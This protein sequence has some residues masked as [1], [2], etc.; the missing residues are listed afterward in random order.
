MSGEGG[1][2]K[3]L[4]VERGKGVGVGR[5]LRES[6]FWKADI[7]NKLRKILLHSCK[8]FKLTFKAVCLVE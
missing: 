5:E 3:S 7:V 1:G 8:T 4:E 6:Q 2:R